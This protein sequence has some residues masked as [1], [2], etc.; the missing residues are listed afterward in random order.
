LQIMQHPKWRLHVTIARRTSSL[1]G[2]EDP[3][4]HEFK[5]Q[6]S[7]GMVAQSPAVVH[8]CAA[9]AADLAAAAGR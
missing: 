7:A 9:Q 8:S 3:P 4:G 1:P 6:L 5:F 2:G